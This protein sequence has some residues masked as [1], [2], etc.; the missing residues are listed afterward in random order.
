LTNEEIRE[1]KENIEI[2]TKL[3]SNHIIE[4]FEEYQNEDFYLVFTEKCVI[5]YFLSYSI[6]LLSIKFSTIKKGKTFG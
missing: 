2:L 5:F 4:Y 3:S 1:I 6:L